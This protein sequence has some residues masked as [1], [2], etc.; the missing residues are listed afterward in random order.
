MTISHDAHGDTEY[1]Y[2]IHGQGPEARLVARERQWDVPE[3]EEWKPFYVGS[4]NSF[5]FAN[6]KDIADYSTFVPVKSCYGGVSLLNRVTADQKLNGERGPIRTLKLWKGKFEG[7]ANWNSVTE[8][9]RGILEAFPELW[10]DEIRS[11][12][13]PK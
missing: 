9:A 1:Q 3:S 12:V 8:D 2:T 7:S 5:I 11:L 6:S 4:V 13:T 10:T